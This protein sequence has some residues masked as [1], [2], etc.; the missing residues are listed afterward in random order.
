MILGDDLGAEK[1]CLEALRRD[2]LN[3]HIHAGRAVVMRHNEPRSLQALLI[4]KRLG[5]SDSAI[6][7]SSF[8][9]P[10][11]SCA[12]DSRTRHFSTNTIVKKI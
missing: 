8:T 5:Y 3:P 7:R 12:V 1:D 4:A 10:I 6:A 9:G 2:P 11:K